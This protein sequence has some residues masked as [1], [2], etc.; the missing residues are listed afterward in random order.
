MQLII[1][2]KNYWRRIA[3]NPIPIAAAP[4]TAAGSTG[5]SGDGV[6]QGVGIFIVDFLI[7]VEVVTGV[8]GWVLSVISLETRTSL[9]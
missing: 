3:K 6:G 1:L 7:V 9:A 8:T 5:D 2:L 4:I